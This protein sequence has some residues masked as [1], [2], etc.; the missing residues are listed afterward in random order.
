[1][2][3]FDGTHLD[4]PGDHNGPDGPHD[5]Q[6]GVH[7]LEHD[8]GQHD[9]ATPDADWA[10][11]DSEQPHAGVEQTPVHEVGEQEPAAE[12]GGYE[13]PAAG[14]WSLDAAVP[15]DPVAGGV[16]DVH[17]EP[18]LS[19]SMPTAHDVADALRADH[20]A[21]WSAAALSPTHV[22]TDAASAAMLADLEPSPTST[23]SV[24]HPEWGAQAAQLWTAVTGDPA[25]GGV[26][27]DTTA[28]I[29]LLRELS[30]QP[31]DPLDADVVA[32]MLN[33]LES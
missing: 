31:C 15:H 2:S 17:P 6:P 12:S 27:H 8:L 29:A 24:A 5:E 20:A 21:S 26:P 3:D 23:D 32:Q 30:N 16:F 14:D 9:A 19:A 11:H 22:E 28:T 25:P 33:A 10:T 13:E 1:M 7:E 4:S 18:S